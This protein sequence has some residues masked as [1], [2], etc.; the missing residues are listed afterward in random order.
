MSNLVQI[1]SLCAVIKKER[2]VGAIIRA[3]EAVNFMRTNFLI[4]AILAQRGR[5]RATHPTVSF[6][7]RESTTSS[8]FSYSARDDVTY[9]AEKYPTADRPASTREETISVCEERSSSRGLN[10]PSLDAMAN[11]FVLQKRQE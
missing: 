10:S 9:R 3:G 5:K 6:G 8:E 4:D 7:S 2:C 11:N 1:V